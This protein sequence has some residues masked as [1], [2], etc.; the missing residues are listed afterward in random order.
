[1]EIAYYII[2][3]IFGT[4]I[5]SFLNVVIYRYN[6]GTSITKGRSMCF[7]CGKTLVWYELVPVLSFIIQRGK[8]SGCGSKISWQYP[9]VEIITG[10]LFLLTFFTL[11]SS[12]QVNIFSITFLLIIMS[13]FVVISVYD[14]R[15]K[16]IPEGLVYGFI[17][18]SFIQ[19]FFIPNVGI[20][21]WL[22]GPIFFLPFAMLWFF[23][24][25]QWMGFGDAKLA[26]GIG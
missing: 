22:A 20:I 8:C 3:F 9:L 10:L 14:I 7:S 11:V 17:L 1:M 18:L 6:T 4:I 15:H 13:I 23:S 19:L 26:L 21:D 2:I 24:K 5:G 25:G 12:G 16:I